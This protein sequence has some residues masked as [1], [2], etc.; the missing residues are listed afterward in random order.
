[1]TLLE[2]NS[3]ISGKYKEEWKNN[4]KIRTIERDELDSFKRLLAISDVYQQAIIK[5][6][7]SDEEFYE[8]YPL[9]AEVV[10]KEIQED[11]FYAVKL[12]FF[13]EGVPCKL[14]YLLKKALMQYDTV[15]VAI[16][17]I[18]TR[19]WGRFL[20]AGSLSNNVTIQR[21]IENLKGSQ[22]SLLNEFNRKVDAGKGLYEIYVEN[23]DRVV[24]VPEDIAN[25]IESI[26]DLRNVNYVKG[27]GV[28][29]YETPLRTMSGRVGIT[30][31]EYNLRD[32]R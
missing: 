2:L 1:M 17:S 15:N 32:C 28:C 24:V 7:E 10:P 29:V 21:I 22:V 6:T 23:T 19:A 20:K 5:Q 8:A 14:V 16:S 13:F 11:V 9:L 12:G 27:V 18:D 26:D 31:D 3:I 25:V 4:K 30:V